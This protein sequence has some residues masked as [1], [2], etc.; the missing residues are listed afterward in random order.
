[1]SLPY[2]RRREKLCDLLRAVGAAFVQETSGSPEDDVRLRS[3][4]DCLLA[5]WQ[6]GKI[7]P[8]SGFSEMPPPDSEG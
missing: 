4:S 3:E 1:M 8:I 2:Y 5:L 6:S 7:D